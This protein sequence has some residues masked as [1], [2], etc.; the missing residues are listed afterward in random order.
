MRKWKIPQ[1]ALLFFLSV[2][3]G[4][5]SE[6]TRGHFSTVLYVGQRA[7]GRQGKKRIILLSSTLP[8]QS[9]T[10]VKQH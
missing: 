8:L 4:L 2:F 1:L 6:A 3:L 10:H 5:A 9:I 7:R